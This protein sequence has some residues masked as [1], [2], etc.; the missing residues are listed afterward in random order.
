[1]KSK[2][3]NRPLR[4]RLHATFAATN[5]ASPYVGVSYNEGAPSTSENNISGTSMICQT[6]LGAPMSQ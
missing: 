5:Q 4:Q 1:M 2:L 3:K 6:D